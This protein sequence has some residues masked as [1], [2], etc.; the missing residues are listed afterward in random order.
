M[1]NTRC[2]EIM[3]K[4]ASKPKNHLVMKVGV[5]ALILAGMA[6][7]AI[8]LWPLISILAIPPLGEHDGL[9]FY[10]DGDYVNYPD[11][12]LFCE[13]IDETQVLE[14]GEV[15]DFYHVDHWIRD[16]LTHGKFPDVFALDI[17]M[18]KEI[19]LNYRQELLAVL[20]YVGRCWQEDYDYYALAENGVEY[21]VSFCEPDC[22]VRCVVVTNRD[23]E[24]I[25]D[26]DYAPWT[27]FTMHTSIN[28]GA[29][30]AP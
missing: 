26:L 4:R 19:Y 1:D 25:A 22:V 11:A 28:W 12:D 14:Y 30:K 17:Q 27:G 29:R 13:W 3:D 5:W 2:E 15:I 10:L 9:D 18:E 23:S 21:A 20:D 16:N 8:W 24:L 7:I 6:G